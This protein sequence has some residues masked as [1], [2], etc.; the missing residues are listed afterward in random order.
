MGSNKDEG[1]RG[2]GGPDDI[3]AARRKRFPAYRVA[4]ETVEYWKARE[5]ATDERRKSA[6]GW[7][8][9]LFRQIQY[10]SAVGNGAEA[11]RCRDGLM[12]P[13]WGIMDEKPDAATM[14]EA[15]DIGTRRH[16]EGLAVFRDKPDGPM[17]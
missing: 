2:I 4:A 10:L 3:E 1:R 6:R 15:C 16:N 9:R 17:P 12:D 11:E 8:S 13:H 7:L 14:R 5:A